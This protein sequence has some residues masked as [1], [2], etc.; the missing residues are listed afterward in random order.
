M[1]AS[2]APG[3]SGSRL[4]PIITT[5]TC[6]RRSSASSP[7][8]GD[9]HELLQQDSRE[10]R[11][12]RSRRCS[13]NCNCNP[14]VCC[15]AANCRTRERVRCARRS[16]AAQACCTHRCGRTT[17]TASS[18]ELPEADWRTSIVDLLKLLEIDSSL[19]ARK[20]LAAELSCPAELMGDS[21]KINIWLH[22]TVLARIAANGG[23]VPKDLLD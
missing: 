10:T 20:E 15:A 7:L 21:A 23:N 14:H 8:Q 4:L 22:K 6:L 19:T 11:Y 3:D 16:A 18:S 5:P 13:C 1:S 9:H 2:R 12:R 17:G